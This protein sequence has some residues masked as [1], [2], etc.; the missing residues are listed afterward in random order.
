M[1]MN[2]FIMTHEPHIRLWTFLGVLV[3]V[4]VL[5][6]IVPCRQLLVSK[7]RR[8]L[9]NLSLT[10]LNTLI[11]RLVFPVMAVEWAFR[12]QTEHWGLFNQFTAPPWLVITISIVLLDMVVYFQHVLFH[13]IPWLWRLHKVHHVDI[14]FDVTT[15]LRFH[16]IEIML[17]IFI[18][19]GAISLLGAPP[20]S[21]LIFEVLLNALAMITHGNLLLPKRADKIFRL[22]LVTPNMHRIH[23]SVLRR[24][25]NRNFGFNLSFCDRIF[26]TYQAQ[27][28]KGHHNM[29]IG[30]GRFRDDKQLTFWKLLLMPFR[31]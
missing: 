25:S 17:S 22:I 7:A 27:P 12:M 9:R 6:L 21:V 28:K 26:G 8:W 23:H 19:F 1:L 3:V 4:A 15:A 14:D 18:K 2:T 16:P 10:F 31:Q 11:L 20:I 13:R 29:V 24:E 30:L 5:E